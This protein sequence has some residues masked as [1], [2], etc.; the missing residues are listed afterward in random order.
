MIKGYPDR[1]GLRAGERLRLHVAADNPHGRFHV[2]LYRQGDGLIK[3]GLAPSA[4]IRKNDMVHVA[5]RRYGG[6]W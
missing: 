3:M 6:G 5:I 1:Q 4:R 2:E